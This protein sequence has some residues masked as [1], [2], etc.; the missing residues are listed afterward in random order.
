MKPAFRRSRRPRPMGKCLTSPRTSRIG[1]S[2]GNDLDDSAAIEHLFGAETLGMVARRQFEPRR[3]R[4]AA[5]LDRHAA[6]WMKTAA[7]GQAR[8]VGR[9]PD[10]RIQLLPLGVG[11]WNG[12]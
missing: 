10:N 2:P 1:V 9:R 8:H 6:A 5:L 11:S 3:Q 12:L 4:C 7:G